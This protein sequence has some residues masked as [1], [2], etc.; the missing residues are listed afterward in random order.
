MFVFGLN[1]YCQSSYHGL[2]NTL[3]RH[4][5]SK[6]YIH[7]L[8]SASQFI[9]LG[10]WV[11]VRGWWR[12]VCCIAIVALNYMFSWNGSSILSCL[13]VQSARLLV[14]SATGKYFIS[15]FMSA[16]CT[17]TACLHEIVAVFSHAYSCKVDVH[18]CKLHVHV[19]WQSTLS[20]LW[21]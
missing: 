20:C 6:S 14:Q 1:A 5:L 16:K 17:F 13:P 12:H 19:K 9:I 2:E 15:I 3:Y 18:E 10:P 4:Y 8:N 11:W 21:V 7:R